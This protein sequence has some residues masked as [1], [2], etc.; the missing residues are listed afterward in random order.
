MRGRMSHRHGT[1]RFLICAWLI[2]LWIVF[3]ALLAEHM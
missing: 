3:I 2:L 1:K